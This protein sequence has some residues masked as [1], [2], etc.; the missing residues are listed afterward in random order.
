MPVATDHREVR[1]M[2]PILFAVLLLAAVAAAYAIVAVWRLRGARLVVC[3]ETDRAAAVTVAPA[4]LLSGTMSPPVSTCSRWPAHRACNQACSAQV[5]VAPWETRVF[6]IVER[7]YAGKTCALCLRP[8]APLHAFGAQPGLL[9]RS[10][11]QPPSTIT[12]HHA[13]AETLPALFKTHLPVCAHCHC[14]EQFGMPASGK[15]AHQQRRA[16]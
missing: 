9:D 4:R 5:A 7:W 3:P 11:K 16:V 15:S 6:A 12:W 10:L 1:I 14:R 2:S 13:P 8:I